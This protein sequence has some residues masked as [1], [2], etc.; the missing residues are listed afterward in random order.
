MGPRKECTVLQSFGVLFL[1]QTR[2]SLVLQN[3]MS[4]H[5]FKYAINSGWHE[6]ILP[7]QSSLKL[8]SSSSLSPLLSVLITMLAMNAKRIMRRRRSHY[9][10]CP[11]PWKVLEIEPR[12]KFPVEI[13]AVKLILLGEEK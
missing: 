11:L 1:E 8:P 2:T 13:I 9:P 7:T 3:R 12:G 5:L 10:P 4:S 6:K